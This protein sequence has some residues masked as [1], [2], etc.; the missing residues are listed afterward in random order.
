MTKQILSRTYQEMVLAF[1]AIYNHV[2]I[3][4]F[5]QYI[6]HLFCLLNI[7]QVIYYF[8]SSG[9]GVAILKVEKLGGWICLHVSRVPLCFR[10]TN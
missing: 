2:F 3:F 1:Y 5:L 8:V 7:F 4:G 9:L 10:A 6:C